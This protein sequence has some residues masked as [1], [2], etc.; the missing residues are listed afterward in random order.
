M[1]G[2]PQE[3]DQSK[4]LR[5]R[6]DGTILCSPLRLKRSFKLSDKHCD[7]LVSTRGQALE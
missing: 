5:V 1:T 6:E 2:Y 4:S 7:V 3:P